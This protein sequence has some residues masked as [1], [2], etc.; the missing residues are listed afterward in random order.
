M[1]EGAAGHQSNSGDGCWG[2]CSK[3]EATGL[4]ASGAPSSMSLMSSGTPP[5]SCTARRPELSAATAASACRRSLKAHAVMPV[6]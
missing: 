4:T 3:R 5:A 2:L 1:K 6:S